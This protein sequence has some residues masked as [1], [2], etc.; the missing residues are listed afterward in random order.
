MRCFHSHPVHWAWT[1]LALIALLTLTGC[2]ASDSPVIT[3]SSAQNVG[4]VLEYWMRADGNP[5]SDKIRLV[6]KSGKSYQMQIL[7]P[8]NAEEPVRPFANGL[9]L[10]R[11]GT[12]GNAIIY[13]VQFDLARFELNPNINEQSQGFRY[14]SYLVSINRQGIGSVGTFTC[15]RAKV[16]QHAAD[17]GL[18]VS[19]MQKDVSFPYLGGRFSE[20]TALSFLSGLLQDG[21]IDWDDKTGVGVL[22][23][24]D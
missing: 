3:T 12:R 14:F 1:V 18:K 17:L 10:R 9:M 19:C 20:R 15:N 24:I 7:D 5:K 21:L 11:L 4:D 8:G 2:F 22:D 16:L 6:R 13:L 23:W